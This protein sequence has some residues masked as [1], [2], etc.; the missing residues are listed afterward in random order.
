MG[1]TNFH[2]MIK[3]HY[4][5]AFK[6]QWIETYD[7][8]YVDINY[9]LHYC[10][11]SSKTEDE[12]IAK[13]CSFF[14]SVISE[15]VPTKTLTVCTDGVAPLA[16]LLLQR[17]RRLGISRNLKQETDSF[18][19]LIFTPGTD[20]MEN[21]QNK[22][23]NFFK[24]IENVYGINV[25]Y[26]N[27]EIDEAELKL[28]HQMM[29]NLQNNPNDTHVIITNDADVIVML[30]TLNKPYNTF[31]FCRNSNQNDVLSIGKLLDLHTDKF[32]MSTNYNLDF[33]LISIML[34]NDYLPKIRLVD[35]DKIWESYKII[36]SSHPQGLVQYD[37]QDLSTQNLSI[38]KQFFIKLMY[39][40]VQISKQKYMNLVSTA[41]A[42][43]PI[44]DNYFDGLMWCF[45]TYHTGEC[46]R[47]D[48]MYESKECPHPIGL[49]MSAQYN[50]LKVNDSLCSPINSQLYAILV[51]PNFAKDLINKK[52]HKFLKKNDILYAEEKCENCNDFHSQIK[53][54]K[55]NENKMSLKEKEKLKTDI[56]AITK[57]LTLHKKNHGNINLTDI[58]S[59][60]KKFKKYCE[61]K[62]IN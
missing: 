2:K 51:L 46:V 57:Q 21:L 59:I 4:A 22:L 17:Q 49:M 33:A 43:D 31:V 50:L 55:Q 26:L 16:K 23:E 44:Y 45:S 9:V 19:K 54:L 10:S 53:Q 8:V 20:F 13:L 37:S 34:G 36:V 6:S 39:N 5:S 40:V 24:Y 3:Q 62:N 47:Y 29:I 1:I 38:N 12:V 41:N 27:S 42:F 15:L 48:Y 58:K 30:T 32:G 7:H 18:S 14:I 25:N 11:F 56:A 52:Y 60:Q 28:K 61:N 35:F